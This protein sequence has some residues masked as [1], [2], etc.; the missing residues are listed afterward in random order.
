[1]NTY[2]VTFIDGGHC[3]I[4]ETD[5]EVSSFIDCIEQAF[6]QAGREKCFPV[7]TDTITIKVELMLEDPS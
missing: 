1:M 2:H 4:F 7:L 6:F 3:E 5:V